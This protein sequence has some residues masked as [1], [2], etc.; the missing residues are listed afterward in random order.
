[1]NTGRSAINLFS[2]SFGLC[3]A[4]FDG[5]TERLNE[6]PTWTGTLCVRL[7]NVIPR[8]ITHTLPARNPTRG[9][10]LF[11]PSLKSSSKRDLGFGTPFY[12]YSLSVPML[13]LAL[14]CLYP[15]RIPLSLAISPLFNS[16]YCPHL[17]LRSRQVMTFA[18][19]SVVFSFAEVHCLAIHGPTQGVGPCHQ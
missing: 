19:V 15:R 7:P 6:K 13:F 5:F 17:L 4:A 10:K 12:L 11:C 2:S 8:H 14:R 3:R 1:M 9:V 16:V 18:C